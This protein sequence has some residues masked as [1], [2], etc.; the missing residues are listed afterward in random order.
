[1]PYSIQSPNPVGQTSQIV[2]AA[3]CWDPTQDLKLPTKA[4]T[5]G[6]FIKESNSSDDEFGLYLPSPN[7]SI[8]LTRVLADLGTTS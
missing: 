1:M 4:E 7:V 6:A 2:A 5:G 8:S 3:C